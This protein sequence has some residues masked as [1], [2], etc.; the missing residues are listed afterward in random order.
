MSFFFFLR[1]WFI[2]RPVSLSKD[3]ITEIF[4]LQQCGIWI[5]YINLCQFNLPHWAFSVS[6]E[7]HSCLSMGLTFRVNSSIRILFPSV[8]FSE[9]VDEESPKQH[10][11]LQGWREQTEQYAFSAHSRHVSPFIVL[12]QGTALYS[13]LWVQTG[14]AR[15]GTFLSDT[16]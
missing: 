16:A 15:H 1:Q 14:R 11:F 12:W 6:T 13:P 9:C 10:V 3:Q 7:L 4:D 2:N 8:P 5:L